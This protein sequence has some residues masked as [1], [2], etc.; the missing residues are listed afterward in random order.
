MFMVMV[1]LNTKFPEDAVLVIMATPVLP[2]F[3]VRGNAQVWLPPPKAKVA[4]AL[5]AESPK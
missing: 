3:T 1:L 2:L 4:L 5:P